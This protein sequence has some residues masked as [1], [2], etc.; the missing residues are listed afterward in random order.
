MFSTNQSM[1][2]LLTAVLCPVF[3]VALIGSPC[4][5][6]DGVNPTDFSYNYDGGFGDSPIVPPYGPGYGYAWDYSQATATPVINNVFSFTKDNGNTSTAQFGVGT[7]I[8]G[9]SVSC[10]LAPGTGLSQYAPAGGNAPAQLIIE[11]GISGSAPNFLYTNPASIV[12]IIGS[13]DLPVEASVSE[14]GYVHAELETRFAGYVTT[15]DGEFHRLTGF[16]E[17]FYTDVYINT[18]GVHSFNLG[19]NIYLQ[20]LVPWSQFDYSYSAYDLWAY[21]KLT[22]TVKNDGG[23]VNVSLPQGLTLNMQ[24]TLISVPEPSA[25]GL[26]LSVLPIALGWRRRRRRA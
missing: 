21:G 13:Y 5:G 16:Y 8:G 17:I 18:P 19:D 10:Y 7:M 2:F 25:I 15:F 26:L 22:L 3:I 23:A 14:A 4:L 24:G 9:S 6:F 11:F 20:D 1:R 12:D